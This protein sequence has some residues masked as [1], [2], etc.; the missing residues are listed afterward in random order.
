M[1][2]IFVHGSVSDILSGL[3]R[4]VR[5]RLVTPDLSSQGV[6]VLRS[7]L[8]T[9]LFEHL[10]MGQVVHP[11]TQGTTL[12][13]VRA[14]TPPLPVQPPHVCHRQETGQSPQA[15]TCSRTWSFMLAPPHLGAP[16]PLVPTVQH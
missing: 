10:S 6:G 7:L 8:P 15:R 4:L 2:P 12:N 1:L 3:I 11:P 14:L 13:E 16:L 9:S 5:V